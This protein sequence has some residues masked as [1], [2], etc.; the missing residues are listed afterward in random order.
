M[1]DY[2]SE[3]VIGAYSWLVQKGYKE[4]VKDIKNSQNMRH[5]YMRRRALVGLIYEKS[6]IGD[7]L[8]TCWTRGNRSLMKRIKKMNDS[9]CYPTNL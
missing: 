3:S 1:D 6:L 5:T 8:N 9:L 4:E 7:F 2:L